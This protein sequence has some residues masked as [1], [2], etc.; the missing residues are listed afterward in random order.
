MGL[1]FFW[2][3]ICGIHVSTIP[4]AKHI[5]LWGQL[6]IS[7]PFHYSLIIKK[8]IVFR[9]PERRQKW[10]NRIV[11]NANLDIEIMFPPNLEF[12][13]IWN[14]EPFILHVKERRWFHPF[15]NYFIFQ[16]NRNAKSLISK[17]VLLK[18]LV[19]LQ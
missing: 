3:Y 1:R 15:S 7:W 9:D 18:N 12:K 6:L 13:H 2:P 16:H 19:R 8:Y 5:R 17:K 10:Q 14:K 4:S 11:R